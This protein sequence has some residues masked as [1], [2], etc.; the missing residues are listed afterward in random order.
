MSLYWGSDFVVTNERDIE[1][2]IR[3]RS[4]E[5]SIRKMLEAEGIWERARVRRIASWAT[6]PGGEPLDYFEALNAPQAPIAA[7]S[8]RAGDPG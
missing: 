4:G 1:R 8:S 2:V 7:P 5:S 6:G 3:I